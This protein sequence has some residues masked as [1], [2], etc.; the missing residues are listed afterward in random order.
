MNAISIDLT[1][2]IAVIGCLIGITSFID[3]RRKAAIVEGTH[4]EEIRQLRERVTQAEG[5][6]KGLSACYQTTTADIREIKTDI[7][8]IKATLQRM[9]DNGNDGK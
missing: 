6:V 3:G 8:W 2:A 9:V 5:E 1:L 7:T 4:L